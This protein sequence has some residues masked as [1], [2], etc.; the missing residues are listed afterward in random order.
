MAEAEEIGGGM[1]EVE[2]DCQQ[3]E[4]EDGRQ[5]VVEEMEEKRMEY[6]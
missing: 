4:E 2:V 5:K 3:E 6:D 1:V